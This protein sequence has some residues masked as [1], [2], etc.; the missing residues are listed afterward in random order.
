MKTLWGLNEVMVATLKVFERTRAEWAA[1]YYGLAY[2]LVKEKF[3]QR[4]RGYPA[5]YMLFADRRMTAQP[6]VARQD[7]YHP[8]RQLM[9]NLLS[10]DAMLGRSQ[11]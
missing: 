11:G 10:L 7:N 9:L 8:L 6:H 5:G 2:Q 3:S 4:S 1:R